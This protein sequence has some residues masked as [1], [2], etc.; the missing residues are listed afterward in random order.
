MNSK[1][2]KKNGFVLV[3]TLIVSVFMMTLLSLLYANI[4]PVI[5]EYRRRTYYDSV[6]NKYVAH[7]ARK[8][9]LDKGKEDIQALLTND[10][11]FN[12]T[13]NIEEGE[14]GSDTSVAQVL[15][16]NIKE[17]GYQDLSDCDNY[18]DVTFCENFKRVNDIYRIY[19]VGYKLKTLQ[20]KIEDDTRFKNDRAIKDYVKVLPEYPDAP[21]VN[22]Y[23]VIIEI[24]PSGDEEIRSFA[25]IEVKK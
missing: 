20:E 1:N 6:E 9:I 4:S 22:T 25:N 18:T 13:G 12:C 14:S 11:D 3:E 10:Q 23:R 15:Y 16:C 5:A 17:K 24:G 7:W 2:S 8:M 21:T 19:L